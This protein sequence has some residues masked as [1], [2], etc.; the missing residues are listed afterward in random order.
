M[1]NYEVRLN[2]FEVNAGKI[3]AFLSGNNMPPGNFTTLSVDSP[4]ANTDNVERFSVVKDESKEFGQVEDL[5]E[6][7]KMWEDLSLSREDS[8]NSSASIPEDPLDDTVLNSVF[9]ADYILLANSDAYPLENLSEVFLQS[10]FSEIDGLLRLVQPNDSQVQ[11][12]VAAVNYIRKQ[13]RISLGCVTYEIG[14]HGINCFLPTDPI[15]VTLPVVQNQ[16]SQWPSALSD[17]LKNISEG[18][19]SVP[20]SV[21][22][23]LMEDN[24]EDMTELFQNNVRN[25][26]I[27]NDFLPTGPPSTPTTGSSNNVVA[28][29]NSNFSPSITFQFENSV[30]CMVTC[31][32]RVELC[33][34]C[35]LQEFSCLVGKDN[36]FKRSLLLI[37]SWW[38]YESSSYVGIPMKNILTE[39]CLSFMLVCIFNN[40]H[41]RIQNPFE[42]FVLFLREFSVY[43]GRSHAISVQGIVPFHSDTSN[44]P[45]LVKPQPHQLIT[46][47]MLERY[48]YVFNV[49]ENPESSSLSAFPTNAATAAAAATSSFLSSTSGRTIVAAGS[50]PA[51]NLNQIK[52]RQIQLMNGMNKAIL[53]F[54]R[55]GFNIIHPFLNKNL[56]T[57]KVVATRKI[58]G[59]SKVFQMT[60]AN[61]NA[62]LDQ[63]KIQFYAANSTMLIA[64][65]FRRLFPSVYSRF[66]NQFRP[67]AINNTIYL[68]QSGKDFTNE[69]HYRDVMNVSIDKLWENVSYCNFIVENMISE[70]AILTFCSDTLTVKGPLPAGELGKLLSEASSIP[71]LSH[72]LREKFGGLKKFLERYADK[73]IFS[74][75]HPFNPHVLLRSTISAENL[76]LIDRGIFPIH[77]ISKS[78]RAAAAAKKQQQSQPIMNKS[79]TGVV[80]TSNAVNAAGSPPQQSSSAVL[81]SSPAQSVSQC[82]PSLLPSG[83]VSLPATNNNPNDLNHSPVSS[84]YHKNVPTPTSTVA[85]SQY[86]GVNNGTNNSGGQY[87]QS[88][89][90]PPVNY[91]TPSDPFAPTGLFGNNNN[92]GNNGNSKGGRGFFH[93]SSSL[94]AAAQHTGRLF[95]SEYFHSNN[96]SKSSFP[97]GNSSGG[98]TRYQS[99]PPSQQQGPSTDGIVGIK[100]DGSRH[101]NAFSNNA[102]PTT[103]PA[104]SNDLLGG[105]GGSFSVQNDTTVSSTDEFGFNKLGAL[106]GGQTA[107]NPSSNNAM[108]L[109]LSRNNSG[110]TTNASGGIVGNS[111]DYFVE[112]GKNLYHQNSLKIPDDNNM[113]LPSPTAEDRSHYRL[114]SAI[115]PAADFNQQTFDANHQSNPQSF[116]NFRFTY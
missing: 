24:P 112:S 5:S 22:M 75:D 62:V 40:Y 31:N 79:H 33:N 4:Q 65:S 50:V 91:T 15:R 12:R 14:L 113:F 53:N 87:Y 116:N 3:D 88:Q 61:V 101:Y 111:Q 29:A 47:E 45:C 86:G 93:I 48:W 104:N 95:R 58:P 68:P 51:S 97:S 30:E 106:A 42:A 44:Q 89:R 54:E 115:P 100:P 34:I 98:A 13:S 6:A 105:F 96:S 102:T 2:K 103:N 107:T 8:G 110:P 108:F 37:R 63:V 69:M 49:S 94:S 32:Q 17:R 83:G 1:A 20:K 82:P 76:E 80:A 99:Q 7:Q 109:G 52:M 11:Y 18:N 55:Y 74:N 66:S 57:D 21:D 25:V 19:I 78:A 35:F 27:V 43:E 9:S 39:Q 41:H 16:M 23:T 90:S 85:K 72:K 28:G 60:Y 26:N 38:E 56:I 73:F 70:S 92:G 77:L 59:I 71:N 64:E 81:N 67:D 36:L 114:N 84:Y 10:F 46:H